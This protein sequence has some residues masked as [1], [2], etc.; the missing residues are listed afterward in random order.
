MPRLIA[1][2]GGGLAPMDKIG[3]KKKDAIVSCAEKMYLILPEIRAAAEI[4]EKTERH[5]IWYTMCRKYV[6]K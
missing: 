6:L 1:C 3:V 5:S 4:K 2:V